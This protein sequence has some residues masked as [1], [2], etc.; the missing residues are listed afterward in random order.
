[1]LCSQSSVQASKWLPDLSHSK[2]LF[3]VKHD[4]IAPV[5]GWFTEMNGMLEYDEKNLEKSKLDIYIEVK[6]LNTGDEGRDFHLKSENFFELSKYPT[7]NFTAA[8]IKKTG[9]NTFKMTGPLTIK[10]VTKTVDIDCIGPFGPL[11]DDKKQTR[12]G[13][14]GTT[15]LNRHD[16]HVSWNR[17]VSKGV[18]MVA[19][20]VEIRLEMEFVQNKPPSKKKRPRR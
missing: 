17:E 11:T 15:K 20:Q 12:M 10:D 16:Y 14:I 19:D 8:S 4:G 9:K 5:T 2:A 6:T 1:M 13:F 18:M 7:I 3:T